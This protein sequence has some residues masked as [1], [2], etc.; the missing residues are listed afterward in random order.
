ML[1][2]ISDLHLID[3]T[4]GETIKPGV[5]RAFRESLLVLF[6]LNGKQASRSRLYYYFCT[7]R[8]VTL[9]W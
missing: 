8:M 3:G 5:L 4:T 6:V 2:I 7:L 1:V 9:L